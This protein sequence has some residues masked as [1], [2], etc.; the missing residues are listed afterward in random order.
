[1][2]HSQKLKKIHLVWFL[3]NS[4]MVFSQQP[5]IAITADY[6]L[7]M[8]L[9]EMFNT[10]VISASK[11]MQKISDVPA[12]TRVIT[13]REILENGYLTLEEALSKLP[14]FQFREI[15]GFNTYS[16]LRGVPN[17]NNYILLMVDGIQVNELNSGGFYG[18]GQYDLSNIE[19]I[20][21]VYGPSSAL[22]GTNAVSGIINLITKRP[23]KKH[24]VR[25][26]TALGSFTTKHIDFGYGHAGNDLD[27]GI[28]G[29]YRTTK[30]TDLQGEKGDNNWTDAMENFEDDYSLSGYFKYKN[31]T[32]GMN[33][34]NKQSSRTTNY[35]SIDDIYLDRGTIWDIDFLNAYI[36]HTYNKGDNWSNMAKIYYRNT[37][38]QD[39]TIGYIVKADNTSA[40]EQVGYYR[41]NHQ[42]GFENQINFQPIEIISMIGGIVLEHE[43]LSESFSTTF[44]ASETEKPS[45]PEKPVQLENNLMSI[46]LQAQIRIMKDLVMTSGIRQDLSSYYGNVL[47]PRLGL[48][49]NKGDF[50][51]KILY[52]EAFRAPRPW[53]FTYGAGNDNLNPEKMKS[54]EILFSYMLSE[55]LY[56]DASVY[57][58][59]IKGRLSK[60]ID[61][62]RWINKEEVDM[63][64]TEIGI[65]YSKGKVK[66]Y[67]FYTYSS[68]KDQGGNF[69][70]EISA[71]TA[72]T[73][74]TLNPWK[75]LNVHLRG[76]YFG[77]KK[78]PQLISATGTDIIEDAIVFHG[79][80]GYFGIRGIN[81]QLIFNNILNAKYY[82]TSNLGP[83]RYRQAQRQILGRVTFHFGVE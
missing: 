32:A 70:P 39:N 8:S 28:S 49:Y 80:I 56:F 47:T 45:R 20:E 22:Y 42:V 63:T 52:N 25:L 62:D 34:Y 18:G 48:V 6:I 26:S 37:T 27:Y 41:P 10:E 68:P 35:K 79:N 72:S 17:Q 29:M 74:I 58:Y 33:Y 43:W 19:R 65:N 21:V 4:S 16:F 64:G 61:Q 54:A 2:K 50:S 51:A 5:D 44:S 59:G 11:V 40:G 30:K 78:N 9:D 14:G 55:A 81:I 76:N 3:L 31:L 75:A 83:E 53:D 77:Q 1:M 69:L 15:Q 36:Q 73:G 24:T 60:D 46:Y 66:C 57:H 13:A 7:H 23:E 71:H 38:V 82:N 12:N 67:G